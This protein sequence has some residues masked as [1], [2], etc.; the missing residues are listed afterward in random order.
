MSG[1]VRLELDRLRTMKIIR[2]FLVLT[3][4]GFLSSFQN[5]STQIQNEYSVDDNRMATNIS[6]RMNCAAPNSDSFVSKE[7]LYRF[8]LTDGDIGRC[9]T[10][11]KP[12]VDNSGYYKAYSERS[13]IVITKPNLRKSRDYVISFKHRILSGYDNGDR[14]ETFLQIKNCSDSR[15]PVMAFLRRDALKSKRFAFSLAPGG[16][17]TH[18]RRYGADKVG[19]AGND[20]HSYEFIYSNKQPSTL[21]VIVDGVEI[22][23]KTE[24]S[25]IGFCKSY[26]TIR[27]GN[28]RSGADK[29][30][31]KVNS[32]SISEY[33]DIEVRELN[34]SR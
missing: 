31:G 32:T 20:W 15:V 7:N 23:P 18:V 4:C 14:N 11:T 34:G 27:I 16:D 9:P 21:Q 19:L 25:N 2:N 29:K 28:Y 30:L 24:F 6:Y 26:D 13:E 17:D 22:L 8:K 12:Y 3:M 33:K 1:I 5:T 10:D